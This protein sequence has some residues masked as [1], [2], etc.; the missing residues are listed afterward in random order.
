[1]QI[2]LDKLE[3][4]LRKVKIGH[5][6]EKK[7]DI[8]IPKMNSISKFNDFLKTLEGQGYQSIRKSCT[9]WSP[10]LLIGNGTHLKIVEEE[11]NVYGAIGVLVPFRSTEEAINLINNLK[12]GLGVSVWTENIKVIG[13]ISN[14]IEV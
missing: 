7:I 6:N 4:K 14:K 11:E 8:A 9:S 10:V 13:D 3:K 12:Q 5:A 1:M 2:F